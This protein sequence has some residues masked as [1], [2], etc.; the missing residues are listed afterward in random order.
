MSNGTRGPGFRSPRE[1]PN[2]GGPAFPLP[3]DREPGCDGMSLRDYFAIHLAAA[4]LSTFADG[5]PHPTSGQR[6][7][8]GD[9]LSDLF[10]G[11]AYELAD[12]MLKLRA[13]A[14]F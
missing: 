11:Q 3:E 14:R 13:R 4:W 8:T 12:A 9:E 1:L 2:D 6:G 10:A 5:N 7:I